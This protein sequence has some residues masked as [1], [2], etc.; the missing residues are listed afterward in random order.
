MTLIDQPDRLKRMSA[1]SVARAAT[2]YDIRQS[3]AKTGQLFHEM[4][5]I[6]NIASGT[7]RPLE[8]RA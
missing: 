3:V 2:C 8:K 5:K 7:I 4:R 1:S 6:P